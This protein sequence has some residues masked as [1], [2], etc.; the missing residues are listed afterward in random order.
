MSDDERQIRAVVEA[1]MAASQ[2]GDTPTVLSLMTEDVIFMTPGRPPFGKREFASTSESMKGLTMQGRS[3]IQ[4][5]EVWGT[6]AFV[7]SHIQLTI[8]RAGQPPRR[9]SGYAMSILRK[10]ADGQWRVFRDANM[11]APE[12]G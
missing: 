3:D 5:I 12:A 9:L 11:V 6:R 10:E 8:S 2:A 7:R 1:W 4:E